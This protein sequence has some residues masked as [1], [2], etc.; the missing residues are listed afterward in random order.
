MYVC[1]YVCVR[2]GGNVIVKRPRDC[3]DMEERACNADKFLSFLKHRKL[4]KIN[5][6]KETAGK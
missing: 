4:C 2:G 6:R 1:V 5:F 3:V